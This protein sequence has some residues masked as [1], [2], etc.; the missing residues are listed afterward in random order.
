MPA[1]LA[2]SDSADFRPPMID[3][4]MEN[5]SAL[6]QEEDSGFFRAKKM[7][8]RWVADIL[9]YLNVTSSGVLTNNPVNAALNK[10]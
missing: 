4:I 2:Y 10:Y 6:M 8:S 1:E 7:A 9:P 5:Y 3:E